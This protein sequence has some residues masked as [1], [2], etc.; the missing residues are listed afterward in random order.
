MI[1]QTI[2]DICKNT[3]NQLK[4]KKMLTN[5]YTIIIIIKKYFNFPY[6][7]YAEDDVIFR[8]KLPE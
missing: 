7:S 8:T 1:G 6:N 3:L 2:L 4:K 5:D